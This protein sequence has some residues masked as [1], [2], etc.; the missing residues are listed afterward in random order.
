M[1]LIRWKDARRRLQ[2]LS[3]TEWTL[4][5]A[6]EIATSLCKSRETEVVVIENGALVCIV[7]PD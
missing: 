4:R 6:V 5:D 3:E 1:Y 2:E 7:S